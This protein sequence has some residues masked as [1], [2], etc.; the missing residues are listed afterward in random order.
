MDT[1]SSMERSQPLAPEPV[2]AID[3]SACRN[4][5]LG[6][7]EVEDC[8]S[9]D[10]PSGAE[11]QR[12]TKVIVVPELI[13]MWKYLL[14]NQYGNQRLNIYSFL[15][16]ELRNGRLSQT[17]GFRVLN[18]VINRNA[19]NLIDAS[20]WKI[21]RT[22]FYA[23][24]Q[25]KLTLQSER[26]EMVWDGYVICWCSFDAG[27]FGCSIEDL[28]AD[29]ADYTEDR[30]ALDQFL[31]P[32]YKNDQVDGFATEV[33]KKYGLPEALTDPSKRNASELAKRM[34]LAIQYWDV[35]EH[36]G[37]DSILFFLDSVLTVGK[38]KIEKHTDGS[39]THVKDP[40]GIDQFIPANT[41]VINTNR[42]RKDYSPFN[43]FHECIHYE[44]HYLFCALQQM[45]SNDVRHVKAKEVVIKEG[46]QYKDPIYFME[47]QANRGA[48]ALMMPAKHTR[49]LI[50]DELSQISGCRNFGEKYEK[51][52][53][54]V[55]D[56]LRLPHFR[57]RA[58]MLQLGY[59]EAKGALNYVD[60][61]R[62]KPFAFDLDA[63][64]ESEISYVIDPSTIEQLQ[65][66]NA[67]FNAL[68]AS[69][70]Y[71]YAD[72]H[73]VRNTHR[74]VQEGPEGLLLTDE[75]KKRVD[76]CCLRFVR[77]YVQKNVGQFVFGRMF[78]DP[79]HEEQT[80]F[81][82]SDLINGKQMD[83]LDA[84]IEY[85]ACFPRTFVEAFDLLMK[86]NGQSRESIAF[87]LH[88]TERTLR[89]WLYDPEH[90][91]NLDFV[92]AVSLMWQL[93]DWISR[94]LLDRAMIRVSEYD[95]RHQAMEHI[96]TVLWDQGIEKANQYLS[97][98]GLESLAF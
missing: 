87:E 76:L 32:V 38:D 96:R 33:W 69:G 51:V 71:V 50:A 34:G 3:D 56:T 39:R 84:K 18:R 19:C 9:D 43:I 58:R 1:E 81:Y 31:V 52:G 47:K 91:I 10:M 70:L 89:N 57:V 40:E 37:V 46:T 94:L 20:F 49:E 35:Y 17:V 59:I 73:V 11:S 13:T 5:F 60:S 82:L 78:Y 14:S 93:P 61:H 64:R 7:P 8:S 4:S 88:T 22:S 63:W 97:S 72:G 62:I 55:S 54:S 98:K 26:G 75:A 23:N 41:I 42:I 83:E 45:G 48:S 28:V 6:M 95:R 16:R 68:V 27:T 29:P 30:V 25:V 12:G 85:I 2:E 90:K 79:R 92:I 15:N 67:D 53:L 44:L 77:Q 65:K 36:Q 80:S 24:V 21:N 86:K 66:N 74:F